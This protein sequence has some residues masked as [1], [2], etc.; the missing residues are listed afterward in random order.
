MNWNIY[1]LEVQKIY[2]DFTDLVIKAHWEVSKDGVSI[3][4]VCTLPLPEGEFIPLDQLTMAQVLYW[5]WSNGVDKDA[6]EATIEA[7]IEKLANPPTY[8]HTFEAVPT[9]EELTQIEEQLAIDEQAKAEA[10]AQAQAEAE[11]VVEEA[12]VEEEVVEEV[13]VEEEV[14]EPTE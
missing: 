12:V 14:V 13:V 6:A 2:E 7:K 4:N 1:N 5:V 11:A 8:N 3:Y 10:E 9:E